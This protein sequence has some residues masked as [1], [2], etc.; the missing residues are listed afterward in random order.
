MRR[1]TIINGLEKI[2]SDLR[3]SEASEI[4][5]KLIQRETRDSAPSILPAF[6]KLS[7]AYNSYS[8][9][10]Q[11][12]LAKLGL[13]QLY[14]AEFW[15]LFVDKTGDSF[16]GQVYGIYGRIQEAYA[17]ADRFSDLLRSERLETVL[18]NDPK[19]PLIL[20]DK[21]ILTLILPETSEQFSS[22]ARIAFAI[23]AVDSF[24]KAYA[25]IHGLDATDIV[26]LS[27]DSGS[28]KSF[29]FTGVP[30]IIHSVKEL[31][32]GI[33]DRIVFHGHSQQEA[34][35][36]LIAESLPVYETINHMVENKAMS[37]EQGE[38]L[39]RQVLAAS[40]KFI[41]AGATIPELDARAVNS[42]R[43]IMAPERKLLAGPTQQLAPEKPPTSVSYGDEAAMRQRIE[44]LEAEARKRPAAKSIRRPSRS[45]KT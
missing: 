36:K 40:T 8:E 38:I 11:I 17:I 12:I 9:D 45:K 28:D 43:E 30:Q 18:T 6:Q 15:A 13:H 3:H 16:S 27:C 44:E 23:E 1:K 25:S 29:D 35:L 37:P 26:I 24:Y 4:I 42:P 33:W 14:T 32:F 39:R 21:E 19:A 2:A 7:L 31:I 34:N 41:E 20:R 22:P 10:E 5:S